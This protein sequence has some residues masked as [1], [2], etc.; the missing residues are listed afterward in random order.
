MKAVKGNQQKTREMTSTMTSNATTTMKKKKTIKSSKTTK[1]AALLLEGVMSEDGLPLLRVLQMPVF[2]VQY[3]GTYWP[4]HR[5]SLAMLQHLIDDSTRKLYDQQTPKEEKNGL[6]STKRALKNLQDSL[7]PGD[8]VVQFHG[9]KTLLKIDNLRR[10]WSFVSGFEKAKAQLKDKSTGSRVKKKKMN[11]GEKA[12]LRQALDDAKVELEKR[13]VTC[14][15]LFT[16][17][18]DSQSLGCDGCDLWVHA[19]M[20]CHGY[21]DDSVIESDEQFYC[22]FCR[23]HSGKGLKGDKQKLMKLAVETNSGRSFDDFQMLEE[24]ESSSGSATAI[25]GS[26]NVKREQAD[27]SEMSSTDGKEAGRHKRKLENGAGTGA[28]AEAPE[29]TARTKK[30]KKEVGKTKKRVKKADLKRDIDEGKKQKQEKTET[31]HSPS[32]ESALNSKKRKKGESGPL[33]RRIK[34]K[35]SNV[36][37]A[38][39]D[40]SKQSIAQDKR[41]ISASKSS[42]VNGEDVI[43][44]L[45]VSLASFEA[46]HFRGLVE[47]QYLPRL[48]GRS[49][50]RT[51]F[52]E[53]LCIPRNAWFLMLMRLGCLSKERRTKL[54]L[55][56]ADLCVCLSQI[57]S[58][59]RQ[60][61][62]LP[63]RWVQKGYG[64]SYAGL[65]SLCHLKLQSAVQIG[66]RAIASEVMKVIH[67]VNQV[68]GNLLGYWT[69]KSGLVKELN[70]TQLTTT[71]SFFSALLAI[72]DDQAKLKRDT[73]DIFN[74][75]SF[76]IASYHSK[77]SDAEK[78]EHILC[79]KC[80]VYYVAKLMLSN[81]SCR[82][83]MKKPRPLSK[84]NLVYA[85]AFYVGIKTYFL[86]DEWSRDKE[87]QKEKE[88]EQ[89]VDKE[90]G[91]GKGT[92]QQQS[93]V[94]KALS[95]DG[96]KDPKQKPHVTGEPVP[97]AVPSSRLNL[98][99]MSAGVKQADE[100]EE[101]RRQATE[102]KRQAE[103]NYGLVCD[104]EADLAEQVA[105]CKKLV[106]SSL[107]VLSSSLNDLLKLLLPTPVALDA[108]VS[109]SRLPA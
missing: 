83:P 90:E 85:E 61:T 68:L 72:V 13:C 100:A 94:L 57:L 109:L 1:N 14:L 89:P 97:M 33:K 53:K 77:G 52:T 74:S 65:V 71:D 62:R 31:G 25:G 78:L 105:E 108:F 34:Q 95:Q 96:S 11:E 45:K 37:A 4:C 23:L 40:L 2:F 24:L 106:T 10:F 76:D 63:A 47:T 92:Q 3:L 88:K 26:D 56:S 102:Q 6:K 39:G 22:I 64:E 69:A 80:D 49:H 50:E 103:L 84:P 5:L 60:W 98:S 7:K 104:Y 75:Y 48:V 27:Q 41:P 59:S 58:Q 30:A 9:D 36:V 107:S 16:E 46:E 8:S 18:E 67:T 17:E 42:R 86:S 82:W 81:T 73:L 44:K 20:A 15:T 35:Q 70:S 32:E 91:K 43:E 38:D 101:A 79:D 99:G 93:P 54:G 12:N 19:A 87:K 28:A 51:E 21:S 29:E 66:K 55:Q